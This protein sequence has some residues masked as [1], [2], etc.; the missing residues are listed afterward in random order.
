MISLPCSKQSIKIRPSG[1][2]QLP[3]GF[4]RGHSLNWPQ[5]MCAT[6]HDNYVFR[7][8]KSGYTISVLQVLC[9]FRPEA[10]ER[11]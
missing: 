10:F 9:L 5:Q 6:E 7:N 8:L 2:V 3:G 4:P 11:V 1:K